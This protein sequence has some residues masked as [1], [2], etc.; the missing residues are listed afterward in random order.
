MQNRKSN[1]IFRFAGFCHSRIP[2]GK[3]MK[4]G[5]MTILKFEPLMLKGF[6]IVMKQCVY[7]LSIN[8]K[9]ALQIICSLQSHI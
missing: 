5:I 4:Y 6:L 3:S 1:I 9:T 2:N 7:F 8:N